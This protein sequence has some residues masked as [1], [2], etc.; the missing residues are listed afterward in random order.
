ME[1]KIN[2]LPTPEAV[3][4]AAAAM[5]RE[6]AHCSVRE[7]GFFTLALSGGRTPN[8]LY[9]L[10]ATEEYAGELPWEQMLFFWGDERYVAPNHRDS[11][12]G[13]AKARLF[14]KA[15]IPPSNV[16]PMN[17]AQPEASEAAKLYE[18][19]IRDVF[20]WRGCSGFDLTLLGMGSDGHTASLFPASPAMSEEKLWVT[21][22]AG[23]GGQT[24]M[25][26]TIPLINTSETVLFLVTGQEKRNM[27]T[28]V[29]VDRQEGPLKYPAAM[30][31]G[32]KQTLWL[33]DQAAY[34]SV[35]DNS[36]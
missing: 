3:A 18:Q 15:P 33:V 2:V 34:L 9:D 31:Q 22:A 26:I 17:T 20:R 14:N 35:D 28:A 25:T 23:P 16:Y 24:R 1:I 11:N 21:T 36:K 10:L 13:A 19:T 32:R 4:A 8:L 29:M 27:L 7:K 5:I 30:A 12:Y 6:I